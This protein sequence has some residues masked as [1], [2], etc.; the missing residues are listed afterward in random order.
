MNKFLLRGPRKTKAESR[1]CK[2]KIRET[3]TKKEKRSRDEK[4][5]T[6]VVVEGLRRFRKVFLGTEEDLHED[7]FL[8]RGL[9]KFAKG[10]RIVGE[11]RK[12][13]KTQNPSN[14]RDS[15]S[16]NGGGFLGGRV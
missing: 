8:S 9:R 13:F 4:V 5:E 12:R 14:G 7:V 15:F 1:K 6:H 2:W 3:H 10:G 11:K 16:S